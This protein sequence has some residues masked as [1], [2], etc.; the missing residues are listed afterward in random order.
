[1]KKTNFKK[2]LSVFLTI[3]MVMSCWVWVAPSEVDAVAAATIKST[4]EA[5]LNSIGSFDTNVTTIHGSFGSDSDYLD[6]Q[7]YD[8]IYH[9]V[10]YTSGTVTTSGSGEGSSRSGWA[11]QSGQVQYGS[12]WTG[13]NGIYLYWYHPSATLMYDGDTSNLPRLGVAINTVMY[14]KSTWSRKTVNRLSWV[15]SGGNG[16]DFNENWHGSDGR[17]NFNYMWHGQGAMMGYTS[18][19]TN[20]SLKQTLSGDNK[21]HFYA[22]L[23]KFTGTMS[24][25]EF[26]RSANPVFSFLGGNE[27]NHKMTITAKAAST[28]TLYII[29]YK[30][31]KAALNEALGTGTYGISTL[32]T[33]AAKYTTAS[34]AEYVAAVKALIAAKPNNYVN[35]SKN[36]Y[37][38]Y[39][40]AASAAITKFNNAKANL[41][42]QQYTVRYDNM[43]NFGDFNISGS[44][45]VNERTD[46]GFTVTSTAGD[47]NTGFSDAIPVEPGKTYIFSADVSIQAVSGGYD[48]YVHTLNE[49]KEGETTAT[50]D[51]SNGAHREGDVYI[52]LTGQTTNNTP[53]IRFTA[54]ENTRYIRIRFD[55]NAV[56][57]VLTVNNIRVY[58]DGPSYVEP[59]SYDYGATLGTLPTP[60]RTGYTFNGWVDANGNAVSASTTVTDDTAIYSKWTINQYTVKFVDKNGNTVL[61]TEYDYG[62]PASSIA[63]PSTN[64]ANDY[65]SSKHYSYSWPAISDLGAVDVTY[66]EVQTGTAHTYTSA[67]TKNATCKETGVK[68]FTCD[69]GYSY[70][71][72]IAKLAHTEEVIPAVPATCTSTGLTEGKKCSVCGTV[73]VAQTVTSATGTHSYTVFVETVAPTCTEKGYDIYKCATC[74]ATQKMNAKQA[75][76]HDWEWV[77]DTEAT[78]GTTGLKHEKCTNCEATRNENTV[79]LATGEHTL[80]DWIIDTAATCVAP[81]SKHKECS[82]CDYVETATINATGTHSYTVFVETVAPTCTDK[83]YDIYKCA[84]CDAKEN[85]NYVD[86]AHTL[87]EGEAKE[88]T[89]GAAGWEAYEYCTKCDY[90]TKVVIPAT[91]NHVYKYVQNADGKTHTGTCSCGATV[92]G[93]CSGGTAT[94]ENAAVCTTCNTAYG[95]ALKHSYTS[96][97]TKAATCTEDGYK[98][99]TCSNCGNGYTEI[100]KATGVHEYKTYVSNDDATCQKNATETAECAFGCGTKDTREI[101]DSTVAHKF[102]TYTANNDA[103]CQKNATETASCAYGCGETDTKEIA[104]S[105]VAHKFETYTAN[106]DATCQKNATETAECEFGCGTK[107][108]RDIENSTVGHKYTKYTSDNNAECEKDGTKTAFCDYECGTKD[109]I[110]DEGSALKHTEA[111]KE[112]NRVEAS[113]GADGSYDLVTYCSVCGKV[114]KTESK[115]IN[116]TGKHNYVTEVEG[117]RIPA[118]CTTEGEV[119]FKCGCGATQVQTLPIDANNHKK[120]VT[121]V[122]VDATCYSTGLTAGEHCEACGVVTVAQTEVAE[123]AHTPAEAVKENIVNSTCTEKGSYDS[124]VYCSVCKNADKTTEI[125]RQKI[126]TQ[127]DADAHTTTETYVD[128]YVAATCT[129]PGATGNTKY[130]CCNAIK[131]ASTTIPVNANA[132]TT[133]ETYVDG[134]IAATCTTPGAT[135]DTKYKCCNAVKIESEVIPVNANAHTTEETYVDGYVAATCT[136]PGATGN[137]KY[138]C[139]N[140]IKVASATIPVN[141]NAHTGT[142]NVV[143]NDKA[144]TCTEEGYTGDTYWSCCD[145]LETSGEEIPVDADAHTKET[146]HVDGYVAPTCTTPGATGDTKYDCC[147]AVKV[148]SEEIPV[149]ATAHTGEAKVVKNKSDATCTAY[150]YTGDIHWSCCGALETKGSDIEMIPHK[151]E[152]KD[153]ACDYGCDVYQG[154]HKD[155]ANDNDHLCDYGCNVVLEACTDGDDNNHSCDICGKE[156]VSEHSYGNA[157][158]DAPATCT[159]CGA[160]TGGVLGHSFKNYVSNNDATCTADGTKTAKCERCDATETIKDEGSA[161]SHDW[162]EVTYNFAEDGSACTATRTCNRTACDATETATAKIT[163]VVKTAATCKVKGT[164][165]YTATFTENWAEVQTLD[166]QDIAIDENNHENLVTDEAVDATCYST[167]LTA[168]EHCEACDV[169]TIKQTATEKIAH[170]PAAAVIEKLVDSTCYSEGSYDEVVYCSVEAC[171]YEISRTPKTIEKKE[172]TP[173]EAVKENEKASTCNVAG[174]YDS[175]VYCSVCNDKLSSETIALPLIAHTEVVDAAVAATCTATGLTE[176]KHCSVCGEVIVAQT[177]VGALGH[178]EVAHEGKAATCTEAGWKAYVTC[179]RCDYTTYEAIPQLLHK[180]DDNDGYCDYEC[181][182]EMDET[183]KHVGTPKQY[184]TNIIDNTHSIKCLTCGVVFETTECTYDT[185]IF[186]ATCCEEGYTVYTCVTCGYSFISDY[187]AADPELHSF[188]IWY[189]NDATCKEYKTKVSHCDNPGCFETKTVTVLENGKPVFGAHSLVVVPGKNPTCTKDGYTSYSRCVVCETVTE[190]EKLPA[191]GHRDANGDGNCDVCAHLEAPNGKCICFC[192]N[193]AFFVKLFYKFVNFFW[194]LFKI[195]ANCECGTIHW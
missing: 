6:T 3:L 183:C 50:P 152:N 126:V 109:T 173:A 188:N 78:C 100:I 46:T 90:T 141:A 161:L 68:T 64:T 33:N 187:V 133:E 32:K 70:T 160:T 107:D 59:K 51:T 7:Y 194:K 11:A 123:K 88:P 76:G 184:I 175:V 52:S 104:D 167:G 139:C 63:V 144:A 94:C 179:S 115:T 74:D 91:G 127:I 154:E 180:D 166:V 136:T 193:D 153:H 140:A 112:E 135:G 77:T 58:E 105:T 151:D 97:V 158:C 81:G 22:N 65:D 146:T 86:A 138:K 92:E 54:G 103:T 17:L 67:V 174:S 71:E 35:S 99:Y 155:S 110:A 145:K 190:S 101:A 178:A 114:I 85:Q 191:F 148:A 28:N 134:Y 165:T 122:A 57:N 142:A 13:S 163:S 9:N 195:N 43:F 95:E 125:S 20:D 147:N 162:S 25:T 124:V 93:T 10:L 21:D 192:H 132:H 40:N 128:G 1:M 82:V 4:N 181:G 102:E 60:T 75:L 61:S 143:K 121:D 159:V 98:T 189:D 14:Y 12:S 131:V 120:L 117:S 5:A 164:T 53:Y 176:G 36:D 168:G 116:A 16:F 19:V 24:D 150:G 49:N 170:T 27:D 182:T 8:A 42:I 26:Y 2:V 47:G 69:C 119:T 111:T 39:A 157:S 169:V 185:E 41:K 23:L 48:M 149:D 106:N 87:D 31:L 172:H 15:S 80:G 56:G 79:I 55:A 38:G 177:V 84:T 89:C 171:K 118:T 96:E 72:E 30:P 186:A 18:T 130:K 34:M 156:N 108:T 73:T 44:L 29:N 37:T 129:T 66:K 137:T 83:G 113:C 45:T 62:T